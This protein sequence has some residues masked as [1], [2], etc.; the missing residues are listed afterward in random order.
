[1][2]CLR[3][4]LLTVLACCQ[5]LAACSARTPVVTSPVFPDFPF[6]SVPTELAGTSSAVEHERAWAFLQSGDLDSAALGFATALRE[7]PEFYPSAAGLGFIGLA[8]GQADAALEGFDRALMAIPTYVPALLGRGE[9]LLVDD[10]IAEAVQSF[11]AALEADPSLGGLR[12]RIAELEFNALMTQVAVARE[13]RE[14]GRLDEA[15]VAYERVIAASPESGFLYVELAGVERRRGDSAAAL[16][17]LE[18]AVTLDPNTVDAW[19]LMSEIYFASDDLDRAEQALL[20]AD[21]IAPRA[22]VTRRLEDLEARRRAA[23]L[24]SEYREIERSDAITRGQFAA[25]LGVRF[26]SVLPTLTG[27]PDESAAIITDAREHWAYEWMIAVA[28]IGLMQTD[29]NYR[30][31]PDRV[32]TRSQLAQVMVRMLRMAG[33]APAISVE[34]PQFSDL[35][36]GHL[37]YPAASEVVSSGLLTPVDSTAFRPERTVAGG[38]AVAALDRLARSIGFEP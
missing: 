37:S 25:L 23:G 22:D 19:V 38:E 7:T 28:Q 35:V 10:R 4:S 5:L 8:R 12:P 6:P 17:R 9:A 31:Q 26:E 15:R 29:V 13:A 1:M 20:R 3:A 18:R 21:A 33:V 30:F 14:E 24:P 32:V 27:Q 2:N 36:P 16:L 34:L 11:S